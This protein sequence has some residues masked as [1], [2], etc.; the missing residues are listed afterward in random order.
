MEI[1]KRK[2]VEGA[3]DKHDDLECQLSPSVESIWLGMCPGVLEHL[4]FPPYATKPVK[5]SKQ[6]MFS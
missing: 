2:L 4:G 6:D 3:V 5:N 1:N